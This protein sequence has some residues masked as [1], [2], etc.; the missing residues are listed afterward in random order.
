VPVMTNSL[1]GMFG[2][3]SVSLRKDEQIVKKVPRKESQK[4]LTFEK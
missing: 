2:D 1:I 3:A 4:I